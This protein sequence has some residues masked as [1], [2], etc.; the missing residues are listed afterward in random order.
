MSGNLVPPSVLICT[1]DGLGEEICGL[2][3]EW[4]W[5]VA[6]IAGLAARGKR[7]RPGGMLSDS[8][9]VLN[10]LP[11]SGVELEH[12]LRVRNRKRM[13]PPPAVS[14]RQPR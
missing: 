7:L 4:V 11:I 5:R 3:A 10:A 2:V 13:S 8:P 1:E 9:F 12:Q 6:C 14:S